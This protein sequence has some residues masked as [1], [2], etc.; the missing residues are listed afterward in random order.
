MKIK[1]KMIIEG[2]MRKLKALNIITHVIFLLIEL[3]FIF[4]F[5]FFL[6]ISSS[7]CTQLKQ[8]NLRPNPK[9]F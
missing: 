4:V 3:E 1:L 7:E 8:K 6:N 5:F 2:L 9:A